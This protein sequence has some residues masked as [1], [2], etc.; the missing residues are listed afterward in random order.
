LEGLDIYRK[1]SPS[2]VD[3][4]IRSLFGLATIVADRGNLHRV[5]L[6]VLEAVTNIAGCNPDFDGVL[7]N[8][9]GQKLKADVAVQMFNHL[10][11]SGEVPA[12]AQYT[13]CK[14]GGAVLARLGLCQAAIPYQTKALG[15]IPTNQL[16]WEALAAEL[17]YAGETNAYCRLFQQALKQ[18]SG[19]TCEPLAKAFS[20]LP[21]GGIDKS[22][23]DRWAQQTAAGPLPAA[24]PWVEEALRLV[25]YRMGRFAQAIQGEDKLGFGADAV[26]EREITT[27]C[28]LAM[29]HHRL[30]EMEKAQAEL[31]KAIELGRTKLKQVGTGELGPVW[32]DWYIAQVMLREAKGLIRS[33]GYGETSYPHQAHE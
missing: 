6:L 3:Q 31:D 4:R 11:A 23:L 18:F 32:S 15:L 19:I 5:G 28:V 13:F 21:S 33:E 17:A 22:E 20:L 30:N 1:L 16:L 29:A 2:S 26:P 25:H 8:V 14:V 24:N 27:R 7:I 10:A 12:Y 9:P